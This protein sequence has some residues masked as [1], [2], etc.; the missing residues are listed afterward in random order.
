MDGQARIHLM[1]IHVCRYKG[2]IIF[3]RIVGHW[4]RQ[5]SILGQFKRTA[6]NNHFYSYLLKK[7]SEAIRLNHQSVYA[8]LSRLDR[9]KGSLRLLHLS[10]DLILY[11]LVALNVRQV[12]RQEMGMAALSNRPLPD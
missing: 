8:L 1:M 12:R 10:P 6:Y 11:G 9:H 2:G 3:F 5:E 7:V 4:V